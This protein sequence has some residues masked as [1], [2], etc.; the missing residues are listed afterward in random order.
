M[1]KELIK[2]GA[3]LAL[4][5]FVAGIFLGLAFLWI[6]PPDDWGPL[7]VTIDVLL[8]GL[9]GA[10]CMGFAVVYESESWSV[11]RCTVT[12]FVICFTSLLTIGFSLGWYSFDNIGSIIMIV[13]MV[14]GYFMIWVI[15]YVTSKNDVKKLNEE[16]QAWKAALDEDKK[17]KPRIV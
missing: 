2:K 17:D 8:S 1:N 9:N 6:S 4:A 12:H 3:I 11:T 7:M 13:C 10:I 15:M 14:V 16:L 5:G